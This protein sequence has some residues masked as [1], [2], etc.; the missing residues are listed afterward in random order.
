MKKLL[1][2]LLLVL[3]LYGFAQKGM[4]G[5]GVNF[6]LGLGWGNEIRHEIPTINPC[7]NYQIHLNNRFRLVPSLGFFQATYDWEQSYDEATYCQLA[8]DA[9]YFLYQPKRLRPYI[10]GGLSYGFGDGGEYLPTGYN[11]GLK[12]G[13]G[14]DYRF[15]YHFAIQLELPLNMTNLDMYFMPALGLTYTF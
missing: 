14:L 4:Q 2:S 9:H 11:F 12:L 5:V 15:G 7:L 3:P 10:I 1:L 8:A 13:F 6:G